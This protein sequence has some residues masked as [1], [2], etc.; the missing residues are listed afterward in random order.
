MALPPFPKDIDTKGKVIV[1]VTDNRAA[2]F[3]RSEIALPGLFK[4][5]LITLYLYLGAIF[6]GMES[7]MITGFYSE[8]EFS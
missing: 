5:H 7:N 6:P 2:F 4:K 8:E 1:M 3:H